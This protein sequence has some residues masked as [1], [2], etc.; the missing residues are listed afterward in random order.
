MVDLN[1]NFVPYLHD[2]DFKNIDFC[3][4]WCNQ[5]IKCQ[6]NVCDLELNLD[7]EF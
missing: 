6:Q 2:P 5:E 1:N 4:K 7:V 3:S